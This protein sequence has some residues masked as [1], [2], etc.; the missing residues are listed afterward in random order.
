M[1]PSAKPQ[2]ASAAR[3]PAPRFSATAAEVSR[4]PPERGT[5][6]R[7]A[8]KDWGFAGPDIE[9]LKKAGLGTKE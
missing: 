7:A 3:P 1:S 2:S 5:L 8:L 9:R 6:G 4:V